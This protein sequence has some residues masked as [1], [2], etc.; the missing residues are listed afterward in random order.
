MDQTM[1]ALSVRIA[2]RR[3][4]VRAAWSLLSLWVFT[5]ISG[6]VA[7]PVWTAD[8]YTQA[9]APDNRRGPHWGYAT[10]PFHPRNALALGAVEDDGGSAS[11]NYSFRLPI[12]SFPGRGQS[13]DLSLHY[14]SQLWSEIG[15]GKIAFNAD[16]DWPA[17]GWT[18]GF[19]KIVTHT[20][21][22]PGNSQ[23][24]GGLLLG[25]DKSRRALVP[26]LNEAGANRHLHIEGDAL[27]QVEI[28]CY[29]VPDPGADEA[30]HATLTTG[31]G[32]TISYR[33][34]DPGR[35]DATYHP[36]RITDANGNFTSIEYV[37]RDGKIR[38]PMIKTITDTV[39]RVVKFH[40]DETN[41]LVTITAPG[42]ESQ[43]SVYAHLVYSRGSAVGIR[44]SG[45]CWPYQRGF[46]H[47]SGVVF[48]HTRH[49]FWLPPSTVYGTVSWFYQTT[50]VVIETPGLDREAMV[51]QRGTEASRTVFDFPQLSPDD[52]LQ[53]PPSYST[54]VEE[55][56]DL[57]GTTKTATTRYRREE[58]QN[59]TIQTVVHPDG[60]ASRQ[61]VSRESNVS[62]GLLA[63]QLR[64]IENLDPDG[65]VLSSTDFEWDS[66]P[67]LDAAP[68][69]RAI[70][71]NIDPLARGKRTVFA[72]DPNY[73]S[74]VV[75]R[76]F[77]G[78]ADAHTPPELE[79]SERTSYLRDPD[80]ADRHLLTLPARL[81]HVDARTGERSLRTFHY[82]QHPLSPVG[83]VGQHLQTHEPHLENGNCLR[84]EERPSP[85]RPEPACVEW[86]QVPARIVTVRGNT[87]EVTDYADAVL[88][89]DPVS[90]NLEYD[91]TGNVL[92]SHDGRGAGVE[93]EYGA[94]HGFSLATRQTIGALDPA[95]PLR[96]TTS[97]RYF[98]PGLLREERDQEGHVRS[99]T[100]SKD[101]VGWRLAMAVSPEGV[102]SVWTPDDDR[103]TMSVVHQ[104]ASSVMS[105]GVKVELDGRA[106]IRR[107]TGDLG[108]R[109]RV[110]TQYDTVGRVSRK[111]NP[112]WEEAP[113]WTTWTYDGLGRVTSHLSPGNTAPTRI[114]YDAVSTP[115]G[116]PGHPLAGG[117]RLS[118][119]PW[120]RQRWQQTDSRGAL[121]H[122]VEPD[123]SAGA[124]PA[125][126]TVTRYQHDAFGRL[127]SIVADRQTRL[128]AYDDL[129]RLI[130]QA[131][132]ER[133]AT[134]DRTGTFGG[135][136]GDQRFSDVYQYDARSN[137]A[138]SIDA[139]GVHT[140]Y[141]RRD[142]PLNRLHEVRYVIP[143]A[144]DT[145][146]P[147]QEV[148]P[149]AFTYSATGS[150]LR[151]QGIDSGDVQQV[152][153]YDPQG[154]LSSETTTFRTHPDQPFTFRLGYDDLGRHA[155]LEYPHRY[156]S[157]GQPGPGRTIR[158]TY[159]RGVPSRFD[160]DGLTV[161]G[162]IAYGPGGRLASVSSSLAHGMMTEHF[163]YSD[164][165]GHLSAHRV[166]EA[167]GTLLF[168]QTYEY[169]QPGTHAIAGQLTSQRDLV[170]P[171]LSQDF[172]YDP[173]GRLARSVTGDL[174][175]TRYD[176]SALWQSYRYD[177]H[178]NRLGVEA[179]RL[180]DFPCDV[181]GSP[182]CHA[183]PAAPTEFDGA[184]APF[185][186]EAT[187]RI[188]GPGFG[189]DAAG[190]LTR[191]IYLHEGILT[192]KVFRYD[193]AGRLAAIADAAGVMHEQFVY[194]HD[195]R[196]RLTIDWPAARGRAPRATYSHWLGGQVL[197]ES[198]SE[199]VV[200]PVRPIRWVKDTYRI[201]GQRHA[202]A[203]GGHVF[204]IGDTR[205]T[206]AVVSHGAGPGTATARR[207]RP[208]G[209][210]P[211]GR[212]DDEDA[213]RF[214][215]YARSR[216]TGL[217]DA[218]NRTYAPGLGRFLQADPIGAAAFRAADPQSLNGYVYARNDPIG[219]FDPMGLKDAVAEC[220]AQ[221]LSERDCADVIQV[222]GQFVDEGPQASQGSDWTFNMSDVLDRGTTIPEG[223][224]ELVERVK[225]LWKGDPSKKIRGGGFQLGGSCQVCVGV[226]LFAGDVHVGFYTQL[227][228]GPSSLFLEGGFSMGGISP[229]PKPYTGHAGDGSFEL[230][231]VGLGAGLGFDA[232]L[233]ASQSG[234]FQ[235][236]AGWGYAANAG[237][238]PIQLGVSANEASDL[239]F[240]IGGGF[241][242]RG[243]P[244]GVSAWGTQTC[245]WSSN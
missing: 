206:G 120:G 144:H 75:S 209:T 102:K 86:E 21:L 61:Y 96:V 79:G 193:A 62:R 150:P 205:G 83:Q 125:L 13:L 185:Y 151:L 135:Q 11:G 74:L 191:A 207:V 46:D 66:F 72:Y 99:Y 221:G 127:R 57:E 188:T 94:E 169:R 71:Q 161:V 7:P 12:V 201:A 183:T 237:L 143:A 8:T 30:A 168:G 197:S 113:V 19:G 233:I 175:A 154:R 140:I 208:F 212:A 227:G 119:D 158:T 93:I 37:H 112:Y 178:G 97:R 131:L 181:A 218:V 29:G 126:T 202:E 176:P 35:K 189:H 34:F 24:A 174:G 138:T 196:R 152:L 41:R 167:S 1:R 17:P 95:S 194:G 2:W 145:S 226:C 106:R 142:D 44:A 43:D 172:Y 32:T 211:G 203:A 156:N 60:A 98:A 65:T 55:W 84:W 26:A 58:G 162:P 3:S 109:F 171:A 54:K 133:S 59:D 157:A 182:A 27:T 20:R 51:R 139:R 222:E 78:Y 111:S 217:D 28:C 129:G 14:A 76:D 117:N 187:N 214:T 56:R 49:G 10:A 153:G 225:G 42:L 164:T 45:N 210:E 235:D 195:R 15:N 48:P 92:K 103:L 159:E 245:G 85:G 179:F 224:R 9:L 110:D 230:T 101:T 170:D 243:V 77:Y 180:V 91:S 70:V 73:P 64:R 81:E 53:K 184:S 16:D 128:F 116:V 47:L 114:V 40:Y 36:V 137:L 90:V 242:G 173:L 213:E 192:S 4:V 220:M 118:T 149:I 23:L 18:L 241:G 136:L 108:G 25:V 38:P 104:S 216:R 68:R 115:P 33:N 219:R 67:G 229:G 155:S 148:S 122:I 228:G 69:Q 52:C 239:T 215:T 198:T 88:R 6:C 146:S 163:A 232:S 240:S 134:L 244:A 50:G 100:Y 130:G 22:F 31:S 5:S 200:G 147:I 190:N 238:G 141:D 234:N 123:G 107:V 186:D 236:F 39:G 89:R 231:G 87:T 121:L 204:Y 124:E 132:P 165:S 160:I 166:V 80:Y 82:D 199:L 177:R 223:L 63:G 105:D